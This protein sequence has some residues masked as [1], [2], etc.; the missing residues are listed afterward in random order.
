MASPQKVIHLR[1]GRSGPV[2]AGHPWVFSGAIKE[3]KGAPE[4]G[5]LVSV[6]DPLGNPIGFGHYS[7]D[8]HISVRMLS[9]G[10]DRPKEDELLQARLSNAIQCRRRGMRHTIPLKRS[11]ACCVNR[12]IAHLQSN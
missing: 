9:L 5:D 12:I 11:C 2:W 4:H 10:P 3:V 8:T 6:A 7:K 1:K